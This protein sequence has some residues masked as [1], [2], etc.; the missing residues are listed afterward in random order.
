MHT[1]Q[2]R[3]TGDRS[4]TRHGRPGCCSPKRSDHPAP[5]DGVWCPWTTN[6]KSELHD[7]ATALTLRIGPI[8]RITFDWNAVSSNQHRVDDADDIQVTGPLPDQPANVMYVF[9]EN[10]NRMV[11]VVIAAG[12]T[13]EHGYDPMRDIIR[14]Q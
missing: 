13:A 1:R 4:Y 2:R 3:E 9:G 12:M 7:L 6:L 5:V 11:L 14:N 10:G 8:S